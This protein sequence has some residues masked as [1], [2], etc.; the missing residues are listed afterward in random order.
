MIVPPVAKLLQLRHEI[1]PTT[2][3]QHIRTYWTLLV[4]LRQKYP[5]LKSVKYV[6]GLLLR[7]ESQ[8]LY[9]SKLHDRVPQPENLP[10]LGTPM[11]ELLL[12]IV[13]AQEDK[14][15]S[16]PNLRVRSPP[17][18]DRQKVHYFFMEMCFKLFASY[19]QTAKLIERFREPHVD[20]AVLLC[21]TAA[22]LRST[23]TASRELIDI[24]TSFIDMPPMYC[25]EFDLYFMKSGIS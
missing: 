17:P 23:P 19:A 25:G 9:Y 22:H 13:G 6:L 12:M 5:A 1:S 3:M 24:L 7:G 14:N 16:A 10:K 21:D 4:F 15:L 11:H 20:W 2:F 18:P 8:R